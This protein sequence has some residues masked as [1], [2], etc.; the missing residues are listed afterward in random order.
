MGWGRPK[1]EEKG[2]EEEGGG[3]LD[4]G[5]CGRWGGDGSRGERVNAS[6]KR[7]WRDRM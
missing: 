2:E 7:K 3:H 4:T 1:E 6:R 5:R